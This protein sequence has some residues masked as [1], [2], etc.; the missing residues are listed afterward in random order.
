M[1]KGHEEAISK[2]EAVS[3]GDDDIAK[4]AQETLPTL[5]KHLKTAQSL[6]SSKSVKP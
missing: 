4:F 1:V 2:F 5:Q 3:K 6:E